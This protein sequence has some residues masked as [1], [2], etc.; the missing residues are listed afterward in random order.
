[1]NTQRQAGK[2]A[3]GLCFVCYLLNV[4]SLTICF[5]PAYLSRTHSHIADVRVDAFVVAL[6]VGRVAGE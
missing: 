2:A 6:S 4:T 3:A 1:M 5:M